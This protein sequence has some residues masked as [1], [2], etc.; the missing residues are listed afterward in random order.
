MKL[1]REQY[2]R[3]RAALPW[4]SAWSGSPMP[5]CRSTICS[6]ASPAM[7]ERPSAPT[8]R[9][10]PSATASSPCASTPI[11]IAALPWTF[12]PEKRSVQVKV[13][14]NRLVFFHAVNNSR[15]RDRGPRDVQRR[16]RPRRTVFQQDPMLLLHRAEARSWPVGRDA[17]VVLHRARNPH[18]PRRR[19]HSRDHPLLYVLSC[20]Q[21]E[22]GRHDHVRRSI[23]SRG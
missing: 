7:A 16:A 14:E 15:P 13:G 21:S 10:A 12:Q 3:S 20:G 1:S 5:P 11:P 6:A 2:G 19:Q 4:L 9:P 23:G 8:R 18:R 22:G 17:G